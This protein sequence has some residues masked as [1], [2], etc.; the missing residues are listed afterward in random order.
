MENIEGFTVEGENELVYKLKK[1]IYTLKQSPK[2]WYQKFDMYIH[3]L[4]FVRSRYD[5]CVYGNKFGGN[6]KYVVL[7]VKDMLLVRTNM[8]L[9][10]E[11]KL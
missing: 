3:W 2:M 8:D 9:I 7:Y 10:K 6:F 11:V 4:G 5:H 1:S